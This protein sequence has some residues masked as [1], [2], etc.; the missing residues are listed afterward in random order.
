MIKMNDI[1]EKTKIQF[2]TK[3]VLGVNRQC[4]N[5]A[6]RNE[7]GRLPLKKITNRKYYQILDTFRKQTR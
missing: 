6:Y 7:F 2:C 5:V 4:P 1:I 3:Q